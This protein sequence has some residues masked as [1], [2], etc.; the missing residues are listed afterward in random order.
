LEYRFLETPKLRDKE[1]VL[2]QP[3]GVLIVLGD[4]FTKREK[5]K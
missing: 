1:V 5:T 2:I 3:S 4:Y